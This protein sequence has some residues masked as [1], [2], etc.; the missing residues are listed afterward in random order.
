MGWQAESE[1]ASFSLDELIDRLKPPAIICGE[2]EGARSRLLHED[3]LEI[4]S[5]AA[6]LRRPSYLAQVGRQRME[7]VGESDPAA[8][9]PTYLGDIEGSDS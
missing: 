8:L 3:G 2:I 1:P 7:E 5:V 6:S 4:V 9:A